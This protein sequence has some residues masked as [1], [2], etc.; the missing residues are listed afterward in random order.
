MHGVGKASVTFVFVVPTQEGV[1]AVRAFFESH[2]NFMGV[3][4]H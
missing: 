4:G 1:E 3:K 2:A